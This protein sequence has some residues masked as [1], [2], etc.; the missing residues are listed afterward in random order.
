V[1]IIAFNTWKGEH[2]RQAPSLALGMREY[3]IN[4]TGSEE[5][6]GVVER[7]KQEGMQMQESSKGVLVK[8]P[9]GNSVLLRVVE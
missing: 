1:H 5:L 3:S 9:V 2:A 4:L 8:D 6:K 7:I